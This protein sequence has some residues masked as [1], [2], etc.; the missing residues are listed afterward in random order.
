VKKEER[1]MTKSNKQKNSGKT[2]QKKPLQ[3]YKKVGTKFIPPFSHKIGPIKGISY[4]RQALPE[5]IWW[6]VVIDKK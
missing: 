4:G 1:S 2:A 6:D 3:D 5:L